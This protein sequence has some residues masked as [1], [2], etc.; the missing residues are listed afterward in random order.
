MLKPRDLVLCAGTIGMASFRERVE[1]AAAGGFRG[2][3]LFAHDY[4]RALADGLSPADMKQ[5]MA[6]HGLAL[7][8]V[9]PL[10]NWLA[11]SGIGASANASGDAFFDSSE[12]KFYEI[13]DALGARSINAILVAEKDPGID[14]VVSAFA[15]LCDRAAEH[16]LLVHLE[17][18]PWSPLPDALHASRVVTQ[19][20]R[21]NG[22]ITL[23]A[24]HQFRGGLA[25]ERLREIPGEQILSVQINDAP[26]RPEPDPVDETLHRRLL[27]GEGDIDLIEILQ[28]LGERSSPAPIG[29]EVFSD[30]LAELPPREAAIRAGDAARAVLAGSQQA[31]SR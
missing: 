13:A 12:E 26:T 16:D 9:D 8:E 29:V 30:S 28:I 11:G 4:E 5:M 23:D 21:V 1:A 31:A 20:G 15:A 18:L 27:P 2:I 7:A 14:R 25:N 22:G 19:A 17:F 6:D 24:W 3:S 10:M